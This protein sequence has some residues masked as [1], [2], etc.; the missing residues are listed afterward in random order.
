MRDSCI[1]CPAREEKNGKPFCFYYHSHVRPMADEGCGN[2]FEEK[3]EFTQEESE[4]I[5][6][7]L[8]DKYHKIPIETMDKHFEETGKWPEEFNED[9]C[10]A[11]DKA[12]EEMRQMK[13]RGQ[14]V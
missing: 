2:S 11:L 14:H 9:I 1:E 12:K 5:C 8:A 7:Q 6:F 10:Q 4:V 13:T 3:P